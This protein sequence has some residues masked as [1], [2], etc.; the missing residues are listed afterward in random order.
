[1]YPPELRASGFYNEAVITGARS[2][3]AEDDRK[4]RPFWREGRIVRWPARESRR[5]L[6]LSEVVRAFAPG[7]RMPEVEVDEVLRQFWPDY[8]LLRRALVDRELLNRR[9]GI[10]WRVG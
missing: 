4:L 1:V 8:C 6:L 7:R 5:R 10:Y 3:A 2:S 9:D